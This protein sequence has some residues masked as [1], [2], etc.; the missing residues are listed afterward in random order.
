LTQKDRLTGIPSGG[1]AMIARETGQKCA[2]MA[3]KN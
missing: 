3:L 2:A 1:Q